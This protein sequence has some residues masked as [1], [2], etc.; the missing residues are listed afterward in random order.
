[1]VIQLLPPLVLLAAGGACLGIAILKRP[2]LRWQHLQWATVG[3]LGFTLLLWFLVSRTTGPVWPVVRW[4]TTDPLTPALAL[5][6]NRPGRLMGLALLATALASVVS[7]RHRQHEENRPAEQGKDIGLLLIAVSA[8]LFAFLAANL[9]TLALIWTAID[10][11]MAVI[12]LLSPA[13]QR[14]QEP[15]S[16]LLGWGAG[17]VGTLLL[18]SAVLSFQGEQLPQSFGGLAGLEGWAGIAL[19][20]AALLRL[21][22]FPFHLGRPLPTPGTWRYPALNVSLQIIPLATSAWYLARVPGW[23]GVPFLWQQILTAVLLTGLVGSGLMAWL[24][25]ESRRSV[26]WIISGHAGMVALVA[27]WVGPEAAVA[28]GLVLILAGGLLGLLVRLDRLTIENRVAGALGVFALAGVPLTWGGDARPHLFEAW[29]AEQWGLYLFVAAGAYVLLLGAAVRPVVSDSPTTETARTR[30]ACGV[31]LG[32]LALGLILRGGPWPQ[33]G[34]VTWLALLVPLPLAAA[35]GW[36]ADSLRTIQDQV[37][38]RLS[39]LLSLRWLRRLTGRL[40]DAL[41]RVIHAVHE[42]PEAEGTLL[43]VLIVLVLGWLLTTHRG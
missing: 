23:E 25:S 2:A 10:G 40:G 29:Q 11:I 42:V 39:P 15:S 35:L 6:A 3:V 31:A 24:P 41:G 30:I 5:Q 36:E 32:L 33:A 8:A 9:L 20:G 27:L 17:A 28:E 12:W 22:P 14:S 37:E 7:L 34:V 13:D 18:W 4:S 43:W 1:M 38:H 21:A 16:V 19:F 26:R